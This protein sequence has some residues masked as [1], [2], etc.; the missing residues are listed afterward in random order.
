MEYKSKMD[1]YPSSVF[2]AVE[3]ADSTAMHTDGH[4][5]TT[6]PS[7]ADDPATYLDH[8]GGSF[9]RVADFLDMRI[10]AFDSYM[11]DMEQHGGGKGFSIRAG[12]KMARDE[13]RKSAGEFKKAGMAVAEGEKAKLKESMA[14]LEGEVAGAMKDAKNAATLAANPYS[15]SG[16][17]AA[18]ELRSSPRVKSAVAARA[19][20]TI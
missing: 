12:I 7:G 17:K 9:G 8:I 1:S 5:D 4:I 14:G 20:G 19:A 6:S 16:A 3:A 15:I 2:E 11:S 13:L 18:L 10:N